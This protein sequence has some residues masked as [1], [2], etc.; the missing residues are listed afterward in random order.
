MG[1]NAASVERLETPP[2][3]SADILSADRPKTNRRLVL[4]NVQQSELSARS[5]V[6][7]QD[8]RAPGGEYFKTFSFSP[9]GLGL[10]M[11]SPLA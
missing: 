1:R 9:L 10:L 4:S 5:D 2:L 3:W 11:G 7:G 6:D 8:V